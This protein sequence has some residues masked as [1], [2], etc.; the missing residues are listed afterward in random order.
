MKNYTYFRPTPE[1][2][3]ELKT[4]YKRLALAN[5]PDQGGSTEA[6]QQ[7][8]AEYT[9]LFNTLKNVHRSAEGEKYTARQDN[10]E[11]AAEF[12]DIIAKLVRLPGIIIELCGSWLW[13]TGET[14][15]VKDELKEIG[16]RW[17]KNK[18]AWYYH[19]GE[20]HKSKGE[21]SLDDIRI[22]YGSTQYTGRQP[23]QLSAAMA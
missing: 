16:F 21:M 20:Y 17:S 22:K 2:L 1:T 18:T 4:M 9:E 3:E 8:N 15:A 14:R 19:R 6:M 5:H 7:I 12:I 13:I 10:D 23:A 11:T